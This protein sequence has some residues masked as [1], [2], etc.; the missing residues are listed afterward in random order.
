MPGQDAEGIIGIVASPL[1]PQEKIK[2]PLCAGKDDTFQINHG[3]PLKLFLLALKPAFSQLLP[4]KLSCL[5]MVRLPV[6]DPK[7]PIDLFTQNHPHQLV[8]KCHVGKTQGKIRPV[9]DG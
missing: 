7:C 4:T 2:L 9:T 5:F 3:T 8:R 1:L 6:H